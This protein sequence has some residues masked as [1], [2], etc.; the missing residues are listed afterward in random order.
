MNIG[1]TGTRTGMSVAQEN[2]V[3]ALLFAGRPPQSASG[4]HHGDCIGADAEAHDLAKEIGWFIVGHPPNKKQARAQCTCDVMLPEEDFLK[5][6]RDIVD[7]VGLLI[8]APD[9]LEEELR[10]GTWA[11]IRYA[12]KT[13]THTVIVFP[14][15]LTELCG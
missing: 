10:S 5:R 8:A 12:K 2:I 3:R 13:H 15:G 9:G 4:F 14:T 1:F 7:A 11:T 6:N